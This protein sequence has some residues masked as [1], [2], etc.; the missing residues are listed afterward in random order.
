M[1]HVIVFTHF[2]QLAKGPTY[3]VNDDTVL[4]DYLC[5]KPPQNSND[6]SVINEPPVIVLDKLE[7]R[8]Y[9]VV[10]MT[11]NATDQTNAYVW[12]LQKPEEIEPFA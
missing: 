11:S 7:Q 4:L 6:S 1:P 10:A 3:I 8:G 2:A 12:T 9:R 5:A